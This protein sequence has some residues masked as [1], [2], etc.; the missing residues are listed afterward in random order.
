MTDSLAPFRSYTKFMDANYST[1]EINWTNPNLP[2][3]TTKHKYYNQHQIEDGNLAFVR[4]IESG[5]REKVVIKNE[6]G[7]FLFCVMQN[8]PRY[9]YD[10]WLEVYRFEIRPV[11][12]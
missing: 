10:G 3:L 11:V 1:W 7:K 5:K 12:M 8:T 6:G 9:Y 2:V 4:D